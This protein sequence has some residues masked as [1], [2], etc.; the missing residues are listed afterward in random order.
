M[1][2][3]IQLLLQQLHLVLLDDQMAIVQVF[4]DVVIVLTI[5]VD[6]DGLDRWLASDEDACTSGGGQLAAS[7]GS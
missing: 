3:L 2:Y 1:A 6:D 4:D 5:N 7:R